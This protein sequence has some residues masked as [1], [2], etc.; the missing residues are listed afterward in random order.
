MTEE[1]PSVKRAKCSH[2]SDDLIV[3]EEMMK[4]FSRDGYIIVKS[5]LSHEELNKLQ[6]ALEND[7]GVVKHSFNR[8]D[9]HGRQSRLC[10]WNQPGND[11]TGMLA[12]CEKVAGTMEELL[13][14]EVY[15]YHTKLIMKE[16]HTGGSFVWHQD[17]GYW[18]KNGC[19][20]PNMGT[21]FIAIDKCDKENGCLQVLKGSHLAGRVEHV[22]VGE[23]NGA[24]LERVNE[25]KKIMPLIHVELDPGDALFFHCNVLHTSD[26]NRSN[27]RRWAFLISYNRADNNPYLPHHHPQYTPLH[28]VPNGAI[29]E[30]SCVT[31]MSGKD[32]MK[33]TDDVSVKLIKEP[34]KP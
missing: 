23:Q 22:A 32:F 9:G 29:I 17:Y 11:I 24:D 34:S 14:G 10:L 3:T 27:R 15:H 18:Y 13:G 12:R 5:L 19:L 31:D 16:A 28:K 4:D 2:C 20:F 1:S 21:V 25:L 33:N 8:D 7:D 30:C 6:G 26:Q